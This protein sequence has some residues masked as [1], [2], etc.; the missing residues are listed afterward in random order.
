MKKFNCYL[1]VIEIKPYKDNTAVAGYD[2]VNE[3]EIDNKYGSTNAKKADT[4]AQFYGEI[5][6]IIRNDNENDHIIIVEEKCVFCCID[7]NSVGY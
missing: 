2:L 1:E 3:S 4:L 7:N 5:Y 6:N